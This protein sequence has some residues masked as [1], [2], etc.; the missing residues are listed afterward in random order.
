M[1]HGDYKRGFDKGQI[2]GLAFLTITA[3]S[4]LL[5]MFL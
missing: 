2:F 4:G 5:V 3:L 1:T